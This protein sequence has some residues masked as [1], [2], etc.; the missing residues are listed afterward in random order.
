MCVLALNVVFF[1]CMGFKRS[2]LYYGLGMVEKL[3]S[4]RKVG[5]QSSWLCK[6]LGMMEK[7]GYANCFPL[8]THIFVLQ[9]RKQGLGFSRGWV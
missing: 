6:G 5:L 1:T 4:V 9:T 7:L 8:T 3:G 2:W